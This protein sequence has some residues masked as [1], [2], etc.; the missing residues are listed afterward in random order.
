MSYSNAEI[1]LDFSI[2]ENKTATKDGECILT[3]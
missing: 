2:P 3:S 1:G